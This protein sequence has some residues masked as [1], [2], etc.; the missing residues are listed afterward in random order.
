[1]S[2]NQRTLFESWGCSVSHTD[3]RKT[4]STKTS[5][6]KSVRAT[7]RC[8]QR[9]ETAAVYKHTEDE[10][11]DDDLMLVAVYEAERSL[12]GDDVT[13]GFDPSAGQVWIYPT[14][15][16][17][18]EYQLRISEAALLQNTLVCLPTG[19]GKTF[20]ASV[21][22]YN[23][24]R[25]FPA[26][27]II[28]MAPTKPL[29]SQ[30]IEACY[31]VMGIPQEHMAELTGTTA[32]QQRR[33]LWR[34]KRVFFLTPQVMVNDLSRN[35]CPAA[36]V[37]CVVIDE[38]HKATGNHAYCQVVRELR[39]Q[40]Q[41][42]RVLALSATPG[43]DVKA[44]QQVISNLLI[45]H[46][47]LRSEDSP[48]V[49]SHVHQR[50]VEKIIVPLGESLTQY[51]TRYLQV[52]EKFTSRL[53]QMRLLSHRDLRSLTKYQIILAREQFRRN[54]P[55]HIMGGQHGA[56]EGDFAL[57]IS[58][59]HGFELLQQMGLRSLF[60]FIQNIFSGPKESSR[61]RNEL[62]RSPVFMDLYRDMET[63]FTTSSR[64]S[65]ER[66][67]YSHPKLQKLDE[68][69]LQHFKTW[70]ESSGSSSEVAS[71]RVMIFSSF[72]ESVQEIAEMLNRHQPLVRVMTFMGQASAGKGVRG[73]TQKE[74]LEVVR[75]FREG[76]FNTLVSTCVGEEGLDIGEVDLIVCFDAQKNPIR[77]V[78]R[79]GRTGRQRHGR[80]VI[81]LAEGREERTYNQ[82]QSNRRSINKSIMGNKHSFQMF[83]HSVRMLPAGITPTLHKMHI[84]CGQFEHRDS[85][86][87]S[88]KS[89]RSSL[90]PQIT[91]SD[92]K[93]V[94]TDGCLTAVEEAMW[95]STMRLGEN[96]PQ[97]VFREKSFLT[98]SA[99]RTPQEQ[100]VSGPVR[101]LSLWEW[102][103]WQNR[104]LHTHTVEHSERCQH[105]TSIMEL[106][107]RMRQEEQGDC[108]YESELMPYLQKDDVVGYNDDGQTTKENTDK[109]TRQMKLKSKAAA[110][111]IR[112][113]SSKTSLDETIEDQQ[114]E[115]NKKSVSTP[116]TLIQSKT[117]FEK[118]CD[119]TT[120]NNIWDDCS[121]D[122]QIQNNS[123]MD[124]DCVTL[125]EDEGHSEMDLSTWQ[126]R[127]DRLL[128]DPSAEVVQSNSELLCDV[129]PLDEC[130]DLQQMFYLSKWSVSPKLR[131]HNVAAKTFQMILANVKDLL[132]KSPPRDFDLSFP[133]IS[134]DIQ[135]KESFSDPVEEC[136][137]FPVKF[138]L[139]TD[140]ESDDG[141]SVDRDMDISPQKSPTYPGIPSKSP[142]LSGKALSPSWD[143]MF[144]D[145]QEDIEA[146]IETDVHLERQQPP[147]GL[148]QSVDLFGNDEAFLQVTLPDVQTPDETAVAH[149]EEMMN[150]SALNA[151]TRLNSS[152][153][154]GQ[155]AEQS[156]EEFNCSQDFFSVNFD[157][158]FS[159]DS[160]EDESNEL[161]TGSAA[162]QELNITASAVH[163]PKASPAVSS[164]QPRPAAG[165]STL[166]QRRCDQ[167]PLASDRWCS[168]TRPSASTPNHV[169]L[170]DVNRRTEDHTHNTIR[171][172]LSERKM[173]DQCPAGSVLSSD[174]EEEIVVKKPAHKVNPLASPEQTKIFSDVDSPV[175]ACR[176]RTA[177]LNMSEESDGND[178][179]D[180]DFQD[181]HRS[182]V[183]ESCSVRN[184]QLKT[185][186]R[187]GRQFLDEEAELSEDEDVSTDE[188][189]GDEQ[190]RSLE[191]FVV[192]AT[193]CSQGLSESEMQ[194]FYLK[195]V[196][197]PAL[198]N[199]LRMTSRTKPN[200]NIFSQVPEQ[201]ESYA[202]D[203]FVVH[204]SEDE[205][206]EGESDEDV[207]I[208][209]EDSFIDGRKQ[210]ATR[211]RVR[212]KQ[213]R[214]ANE[215]R[216]VQ[217]EN[218]RKNKC[219]RIIRVQDSSEDE[220]ETC[221][222]R[223]DETPSVFKVPQCLQNV[224]TVPEKRAR[225]TEKQ[226]QDERIRQRLRDQ[227][228]LS[229]QLD[230]QTDKQVICAAA[231][232][233]SPPAADAPLSVLVDSRCI[234]GGSEVVSSLRLKHRVKVH[235]CSLV[236]SDFI[237]S[238]RMSVD[239]HSES[240]MSS[241]QNRR[242]LQ[243]RMQKLEA[244]YERVCLI[245]E[246]DR[247]KP[248][249]TLRVFQRSRY[250]DG[251]LAAL[252]KVGVRL[253][254]SNSPDETATILTNL[255]Q[256]EKRK[257][258]GICVPLEVK[259]HRQQALQFCLA[260][261]HVS[262]INALNMCH[263]Y[264]SISHMI[265]SSL[266][267]L[268]AFACVNRSRAEEIYR[269]LR[270]SC[271][272]TLM[273]TG[274]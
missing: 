136:D 82:S 261:P 154:E 237:V 242:R 32:A 48:D 20:I 187:G 233:R 215:V 58:L 61:V 71:T 65:K 175:Q 132:S 229:D 232:N 169:L 218:S 39:N 223:A 41:Q 269:S 145:G 212:I 225:L 43:G 259:G 66:H 248:G 252:V 117:S 211:R 230:F 200:M 96:E 255:T 52:L 238:N 78:Q 260:L 231:M 193:Q 115:S 122:R 155:R 24:Y 33:E 7:D 102:R 173:F 222:R 77:L 121:R 107:D 8:E 9:G 245:I 19:L 236:S 181:V 270:Y 29:V 54:P 274:N 228:A 86:R 112:R 256:V 84:S 198:Q 83:P 249:E 250:Y 111:S 185:N 119:I 161:D 2:N 124:V 123:G 3:Q 144:D 235:V 194:A 30:Q 272:S 196:R 69:V 18:R 195:S 153:T 31:R 51:Q 197:S 100:C 171:K 204:G 180:E 1:M 125:T 156:S 271:D 11:D 148:D 246:K 87:T 101:E 202:E 207:Q 240:D 79:M 53:T 10:D 201:D 45:S 46:I 183:L 139:R 90:N 205:D 88:I 244:L 177:A 152:R 217:S 219:S 143:E 137:L 62:Q 138:C 49:K 157:L 34:S 127:M 182:R 241:V 150:T 247:P 129:Q 254:F 21:L 108:S 120:L 158:G 188:D 174:S 224:S 189:D 216:D 213:I 176:K 267:E 164:P 89:R 126:E 178:G 147:T 140:E 258:H 105:F 199:H 160:D 159:I 59:Y 44:V 266:D 14:N 210:Y 257:G 168:V 37:K 209:P 265:N 163:K 92:Q 179:S 72:R 80:I 55:P 81:I 104:P 12:Q 130:S 186:V 142:Q 91:G 68:V 64:E 253:M 95:T 5:Q 268:Q 184:P 170:C 243:D 106:I 17:V 85:G 109:I 167:S 116:W 23:Y 28:F 25:W 221:V 98:F 57:C 16:P 262:Y 264:T 146:L 4:T 192:N 76:G 251:T 97:P 214:A 27:K 22:M 42:F 103:H 35:T 40:T 149:E 56:L 220:E 151:T 131:P 135:P 113:P 60:L 93:C 99:N 234:S 166:I 110:H 114:R 203:S 191:G 165:N 94:K 15:Y 172:S 75:R 190:N 74:Q 36:Q 206:E 70:A 141:D 134:A 273:T 128:E 118:N 6:G 227:T 63:M 239:W 50:S 26:G 38:A 13:S 162:K 47:E 226:Q 263:H 133:E 67:V 208:I 73:F